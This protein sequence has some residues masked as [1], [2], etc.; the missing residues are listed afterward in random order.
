MIKE[1]YQAG[2]GKWSRRVMLKYALLQIPSLAAVVLG[3]LLLRQYVEIP[4]WLCWASVAGWAAKDIALYPLTWKAYDSSPAGDR[5][6][7][8]GERGVAREQ[9]NPAGHV[10]VR[11]A[12]WRAQTAAGARPVAAGEAVRVR[13]VRGLTLIVEPEPE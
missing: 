6:S 3:L 1:R 13:A 7:L 5:F 12:L 4:A 2:S 11:G 9:L 8:V 10:R